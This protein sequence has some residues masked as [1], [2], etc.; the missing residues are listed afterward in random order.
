LKTWSRGISSDTKIQFHMALH[1]I[2]HLDLAME[3][4]NLSPEER[5]IRSRLKREIIG[6]EALGRTPKR[7]KGR[8]STILGMELRTQ[9][10]PWKSEL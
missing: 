2:L 3:R 9:K 8:G 6:L 1:V 7:Q 10:N 4:R 5:A